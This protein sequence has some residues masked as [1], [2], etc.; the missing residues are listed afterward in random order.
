M[1]TPR[2]KKFKRKVLRQQ[3]LIKETK[4]KLDDVTQQTERNVTAI[5]INTWSLVAYCTETYANSKRC[6]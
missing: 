2:H 3:Q 1:H 6:V 5:T 4:A